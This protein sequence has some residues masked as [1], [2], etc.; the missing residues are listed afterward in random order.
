MLKRKPKTQAVAPYSR[1]ASIY[2]Y[3]MRHV[4]YVHWADYMA[5]LFTR[6]ELA[7]DRVLDL[8]C[9]TGSLALEFRRRGYRIAGADGCQDM[10]RVAEEKSRKAGYDI[11]FFHRNLLDLNGLPRSEGV[12]CLYDSLNYLM[13][14]EDISTVLREA[15]EVV[16][17]GGVFIFDVCTETNSLRYFRDMKEKDR[18]EGFSYTRHSFYEDGVQFNRFEIHFEDTQEVVCELHQQRIYP[19]SEIER[20]IADSP[21]E[22]KDAYDG[23]GLTRP[24]ETSDR[25]HFVLRRLAQRADRRD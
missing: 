10:L 5:L 21:F 13:T 16:A 20:V 6:H 25:V 22:Q 8:A 11:P 24:G 4:D 1:L 3:V 18:G 2:D 19:L 23:F 15:W 14:L 17:P 9:G 7:P 12:L